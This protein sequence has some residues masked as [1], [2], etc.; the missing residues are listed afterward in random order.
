MGSRARTVEKNIMPSAQNQLPLPQTSATPM[1]LADA[2]AHVKKFAEVGLFCPCCDQFVK[3]YRRKITSAMT[4]ALI[5]LYKATTNAY[6]LLKQ[7]TGSDWV[8]MPTLLASKRLQRSDEAKLVYWELIEPFTGTR[9]DGSSRNGHYR[10]TPK[11][12]A[13]VSGS[14]PVPKYAYVSNSKVIRFSD[15]KVGIEACLGD[16]FNYRELMGA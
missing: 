13:F 11:G 16:K 15:E 14:L 10:I 6:K 8:H 7:A 4:R 12:I 9:E 3:V 1:T 2:R 5:E